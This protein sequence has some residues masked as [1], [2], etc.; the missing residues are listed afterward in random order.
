MAVIEGVAGFYTCDGGCDQAT[1]GTEYAKQLEKAGKEIFYYEKPKAAK[2][3]DGSV[4]NT[5]VGF[6]LLD[7]ELI[8]KAGTVVL[9]RTHIDAVSYTHLTLPTTPYV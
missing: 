3:A 4:K 6:C 7:V 8:T 9:P 2:L 1:I 5:I